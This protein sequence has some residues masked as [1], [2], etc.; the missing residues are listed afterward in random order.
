MLCCRKD[1]EKTMKKRI[2]IFGA[3]ILVLSIALAILLNN[4]NEERKSENGKITLKDQN[5]INT[6]ERNKRKQDAKTALTNLNK[7]KQFLS[8]ESSERTTSENEKGT[9]TAVDETR[10]KEIIG[11]NLV[12]FGPKALDILM[13]EQNPDFNWT[14]EISTKG[15]EFLK[16]EY[17]G[18][19]IE[20]VECREMVCKI[21]LK[22]KNEDQAKL[23]DETDGGAKGPWGMRQFGMHKVV[24]GTH[25]SVLY[26]ER[27]KTMTT[28]KKMDDVMWDLI[29]K[30]N[31]V[32]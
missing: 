3:V 5:F 30:E 19:S 16:R 25:F 9:L 32:Q 21:E 17:N 28:F 12:E 13:E 26:I 18:T 1:L 31:R 7:V 8:R 14:H 27:D 4:S 15:D 29:Q 2:A 11:E 6:E 24:D 20:S 10:K 22:H 23:F